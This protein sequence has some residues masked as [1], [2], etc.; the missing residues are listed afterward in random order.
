MENQHDLLVDKTVFYFENKGQPLCLTDRDQCFW[1][2]SSEKNLKHNI[3]VCT[4]WKDLGYLEFFDFQECR[5]RML[6]KNWQ[7]SFE[8]SEIIQFKKRVSRLLP[9]MKEECTVSFPKK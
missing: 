7:I 2:R 1:I 5:K 9:F 6:L 4:K 3:T 8:D